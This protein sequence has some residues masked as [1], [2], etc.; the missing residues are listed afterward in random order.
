MLKEAI[1]KVVSG[2][3]LTEAE[4]TRAMEAIMNGEA[5]EAQIGA[6]ITGLQ[7]EGRDRGRDHRRGPGD[8]GQGHPHPHQ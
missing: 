2:Q 4:M 6:F 1:L 7:D 5:T 3:D 8:A